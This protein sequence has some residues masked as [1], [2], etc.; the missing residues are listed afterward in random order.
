[1][2]VFPFPTTRDLSGQAEL[3]NVILDSFSSQNEEVKSAASYALG[4]WE[5]S[6]K[7]NWKMVKIF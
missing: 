6:N 1:M 7:S 4:K 2:R 3:A 5:G